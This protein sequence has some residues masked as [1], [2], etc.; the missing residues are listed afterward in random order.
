MDTPAEFWEI[1]ET[2]EK[3]YGPATFYR[4][5]PGFFNYAALYD[6]AVARAHVGDCYVESG[7]CMGAS[8]TYLCDMLDKRGIRVEVDLID[9]WGPRRVAADP[10]TDEFLRLFPSRRA[11]FD[12]CAK[13]VGLDKRA[14]VR[15]GDALDLLATYEPNSLGFVFLDDCHDYEH[16]RKEI[17]LVL[18]RL[19]SGGV[20]AGHDYCDN[21]DYGVKRAVD[22]LLG[23]VEIMCT[24]SFWY[25]K[26]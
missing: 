18:P 25:E 19:R 23:P 8:A 17:E 26:P 22:E 3:G 5:V 20:L 1:S 10:L 7:V 9:D 21:P 13:R 24:Q 11:A 2:V 14:T 15:Q 12:H 4:G 6:R 16:V